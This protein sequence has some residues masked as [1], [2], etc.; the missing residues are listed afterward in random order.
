MRGAPNH[1]FRNQ[2]CAGG[3]ERLYVPAQLDGNIAGSVWPGSELRHGAEIF[4]LAWSKTIKSNAK[5][6]LVKSGNSLVRRIQ[7]I[8]SPNRVLGRNIP[9]MLAPLL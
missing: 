7:H 6:A 8:L 4:F 2:A 3:A 1:P 9:R 5:K